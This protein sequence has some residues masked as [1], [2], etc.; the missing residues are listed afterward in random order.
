MVSARNAAAPAENRGVHG[1]RTQQTP[2]YSTRNDFPGSGWA[3]VGRVDAGRTLHGVWATEARTLCG[4][5]P[6]ESSNADFAL[7]RV[8]LCSGICVRCEA[9]WRAL[10][11][12]AA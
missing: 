2:Q 6:S 9:R 12:G 4:R 8:V 7:A 10:A 11:R 5:S 3:F 1:R